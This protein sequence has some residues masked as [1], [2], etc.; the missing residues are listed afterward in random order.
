[1][2]ARCTG[3]LRRRRGT[4]EVEFTAEVIT[5]HQARNKAAKKARLKQPRK[6]RRFAAL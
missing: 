5:Y 3:L 6:L 1:M 4:G 2:N